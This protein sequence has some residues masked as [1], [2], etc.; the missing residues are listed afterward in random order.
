MQPKSV[1]EILL[2]RAGGNEVGSMNR[3]QGMV[4]RLLD[5]FGSRA[6]SSSHFVDRHL[7]ELRRR[8]NPTLGQR[9]EN[10]AAQRAR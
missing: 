1:M 4:R 9:G 6:S 10:H 2:L 7:A 8:I 5:R 3:N